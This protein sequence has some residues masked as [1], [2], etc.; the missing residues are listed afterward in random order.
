MGD[1]L[2]K[3]I[4]VT[5]TPPEQYM[6]ISK[7]ASTLFMFTPVTVEQVDH[8][9][10]KLSTSKSC[11]LEKISSKLLKLANPY[12]SETIRDIINQSLDT[13]IFPDDW[14]KA[15]VSPVYKADARNAPDNYRPISILPAISKVIERIVHTQVL[16]FFTENNLL[17][18][19]QSGFRGM[20]STC[21]A[22]L[23]ATDLWLRNIDEGILTGNV[24]I[25]LKKAFDTVDHAILV[26]KIE[27]LWCQGQ[28]PKVV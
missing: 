26:T 10:S 17:S 9:I 22:L 25:D 24:F 1:K 16:E 12:I 21:T 6:Y 23:F 4:P 2:A 28:I 19:F 5:G 11:G 20:H 8:V 18:K 13:G 3:N 7:R 15:K 14:K 27:L